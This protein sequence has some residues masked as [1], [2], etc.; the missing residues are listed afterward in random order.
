MAT[1]YEGALGMLAV[2]H[3]RVEI[4]EG[5]ERGVKLRAGIPIAFR[6]EEEVRGLRRAPLP[7]Q[8]PPG[9]VVEEGQPLRI[10]METSPI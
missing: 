3:Q 10:F 5:L 9:V 6:R 1:C 7:R 4:E 2:L 8:Y